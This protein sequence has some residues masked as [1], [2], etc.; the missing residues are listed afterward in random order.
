[1]KRLEHLEKG[2][3]GRTWR[4]RMVLSDGSNL[5]LERLH[6]RKIMHLFGPIRSFW[7]TLGPVSGGEQAITGYGYGHA[8]GMSQWGA[9]LYAKAGWDANRILNHFYYNIK[10]ADL[11]P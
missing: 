9:Q 8:V 7:Y 6:T 11:A 10:I 5:D 1:M 4:L 3:S 2:V